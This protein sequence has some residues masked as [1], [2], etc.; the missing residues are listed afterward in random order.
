M[1]KSQQSLGLQSLL[2]IRKVG[3]LR[4]EKAILIRL[5]S[6]VRRQDNSLQGLNLGLLKIGASRSSLPLCYGSVS[7][8]AAYFARQRRHVGEASRDFG[9]R[10]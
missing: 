2:G 4:G 7:F 3:P 5:C 6:P 9:A 8:R 10:P 1:K